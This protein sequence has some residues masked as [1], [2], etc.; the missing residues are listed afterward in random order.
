MIKL[1]AATRLLAQG[2]PKEE[3]LMLQRGKY[4]VIYGEGER[5]QVAEFGN[6]QFGLIDSDEADTTKRV[7]QTGLSREDAIQ[8]AKDANKRGKIEPEKSE[9]STKNKYGG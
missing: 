9:R 3:D 7:K 5:F 6:N 8:A 1:N 2:T 4:D